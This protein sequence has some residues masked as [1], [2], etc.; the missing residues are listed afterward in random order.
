MS[1][2]NWDALYNNYIRCLVGSVLKS[3]V[4]N[5]IEYI[6]NIKINDVAI[7]QTNMRTDFTG[8]IIC[9]HNITLAEQLLFKIKL[10]S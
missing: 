9:L 1:Q 7:L 2:V 5:D 6:A 10:L 4:E 8:F 3:K